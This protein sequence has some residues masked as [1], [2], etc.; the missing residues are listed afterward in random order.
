MSP[1]GNEENS[2]SCSFAINF[3]MHPTIPSKIG[4]FLVNPVILPV[5]PRKTGSRNVI[6]EKSPCKLNIVQL[7]KFS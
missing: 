7:I 6:L 5:P 4:S 3:R 2:Y 1:C